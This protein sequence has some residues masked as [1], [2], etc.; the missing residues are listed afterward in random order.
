MK[1]QLSMCKLKLGT[2]DSKPG[3]N[4]LNSPANNFNEINC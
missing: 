2:Y 3:V 4:K 1:N